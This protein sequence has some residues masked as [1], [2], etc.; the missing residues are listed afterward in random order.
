[1]STP[2]EKGPSFRQKVKEF[3]DKAK[4]KGYSS[5]NR[6]MLTTV[7]VKKTGAGTYEVLFAYLRRHLRKSKDRADLRGLTIY[8]R[9]M[10]EIFRSVGINVGIY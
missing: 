7:L 2:R 1:M 9:K 5:L 3:E 10:I 4:I 6:G 8:Q